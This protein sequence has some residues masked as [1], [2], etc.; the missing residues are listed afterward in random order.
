MDTQPD[1]L[2]DRIPLR[3]ADAVPEQLLFRRLTI[4]FGI[5]AITTAVIGILTAHF[6]ITLLGSALPDNKTIALSAALIWIFLGSVLA[7][8]AVKPLQRVAGLVVQAVLILIAVTLTI[9]FVFSLQGIHFF[10]ENLF[11]RVGTTIFGPSSSPISPVAAGLAVP[12]ALALVFVIRSPGPSAKAARVPDAIS[13]LGLAISLISFTFLLSYDFGDP[14]L[15]GTEYIPIAAFSALAAFFIGA[16]VVAAAGPGAVPVKYMFGDS[17]SAGIL[18]IFVPLVVGIVLVENVVFIGLPSWFRIQDSVLLSISFVIF[19]FITAFVVAKVSGRMGRALERAEQELVKK[20]EDLGTMNE[21]LTATQEELRQNIEELTRAEQT[22]CESEEKFRTVAN[23]TSD[24]EYWLGPDNHL[25]YISP[26]CEQISGYTVQ[27]FMDNNHLLDDLVHPE[28]RALFLEHMTT[29]GGTGEIGPVDFRIVKKDGEVRWIGHACRPVFSADGT[30]L[31]RR[32][33]NRD[34]TGRRN[35][36]EE[37]KQKHDDLTA[38]NEELTATQEE[39][40]QN[41]DHLVQAETALKAANELL[42]QRVAERTVQLEK[43]VK[44]T[45]TER[46]R[47]YGVLETLPVYVCL[48]DAEYHMPFANR[49][50]RETFAE[51]HGR[52]CYDFLFNR[53]EPCE[54]CETYTVMKTKAPH[55]WYWTGPNGRDYDIYDF[56]FTDTD[57]SFLILEMGIDITERNKAVEAMKRSGAYNRSL[58]EASLDPL[59]TINPDG[60]ISDVNAATAVVTGFSRKELIGTDFSQYLTEPD[61][62]KAGYETVFRDGSVTDYA[63][64]IRHRDGHTT[65]VLYNATVFR[66]ESGNIEGVFAVARDITERKNAEAALQ[67]AYD[68]LEER[69]QQR[70]AELAT[71]NIRLE[72]EVIERR[73]AEEELKR[74]YEDLNAINEE[75]SA[76][77]G[78]LRQNVGELEKNESELKD[79]LA[80]KEVLLSEIHHRVKNNLTAFISLLSLDGSYDVSPAGEALR[81]DLQNRARSMALIHETLYRT[82]KFS[83][84]DMEIYLTTLVSQIADTYAG[85]ATI[86]TTVDAR[87]VSLDLPR[88]T[89]AGLIINELVTNSFKYAFPPGFDCMA[90]RGEPC[91]IRVSLAHKDGTY[92][93]TVADNGRGLP[94]E[95]DPLKTKSLGLKLV[96]F[97]A[98]HQ[99]RAEIGVRADKGTEFMFRLINTEDYK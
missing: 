76:T 68:E 64:K 52:C 40:R 18:R 34:I 19:A 36:E 20:N 97:L 26:S 87:G 50:F 77:Q 71:T 74:R 16:A 56:P 17:T 45:G 30:P 5:L 79:A 25:I 96:N 32:V 38:L 93:L 80:E 39:L 84:V 24:W 48:L 83:N 98:R 35:A 27:E 66:D 53:T 43:A 60:T 65:P 57:G 31:G 22:L 13:I 88:A 14:L 11:V 4:T 73:K 62:A 46:Q 23:F 61:R 1:S 82:G 69:V 10:I 86:R 33:S 92:V 75:L 72:S 81:K 47:L 63:L 2:Q 29:H 9:E 55:H 3:N 41:L 58:I 28:D 15:Y 78:Q 91:T 8:Q 12:A 94:P 51:P 90:V 21:E 7:Y 95:F 6:G 85:S 99:L 49:Y 44:D 42:E 89:T 37:L 67:K 54:T 70:T 59:V